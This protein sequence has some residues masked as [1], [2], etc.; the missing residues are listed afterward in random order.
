MEKEETIFENTLATETPPGIP[1]RKELFPSFGG[2]RGGLGKA[3]KN[4]SKSE[5]LPCNI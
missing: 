3:F 4:G 2:V 1:K 5:D